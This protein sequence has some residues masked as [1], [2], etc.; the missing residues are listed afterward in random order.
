[1]DWQTTF[2][3]V[4]VALAAAWCGRMLYAS[5]QS[6]LKAP[7]A[8]GGCGGGCGCSVPLS[9]CDTKGP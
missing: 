8:K 9:P 3:L 1:M 2:S 5:V 6:A 7:D 4:I